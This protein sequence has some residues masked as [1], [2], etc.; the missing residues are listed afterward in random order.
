MLCRPPSPVSMHL[1]TT[2]ASVWSTTSSP[3]T[4]SMKCLDCV[5]L[6]LISQPPAPGRAAVWTVLNVTLYYTIPGP[7]CWRRKSILLLTDMRSRNPALCPPS[8]SCSLPRRATSWC[9]PGSLMSPAAAPLPC[10]PALPR[11]QLRGQ[12]RARAGPGLTRLREATD[13][14]HLGL[15]EGQ[16]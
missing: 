8:A 11:S 6:H 4:S 13:K 15:E 10:L 12:G 7:I 3:S 2:D 5:Q 9:W 16:S 14:E 1:N